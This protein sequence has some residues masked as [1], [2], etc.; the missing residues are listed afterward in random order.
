M[1]YLVKQGGNFI[2]MDVSDTLKKFENT[3]KMKTPDERVEYLKSL[4]FNVTKMND[5]DIIKYQSLIDLQEELFERREN[6]QKEIQEINSRIK[7]IDCEIEKL[8][9][10]AETEN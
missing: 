9:Q 10:K 4:G 1:L 7:N 8:Y 2:M 3:L 6:L 5:E